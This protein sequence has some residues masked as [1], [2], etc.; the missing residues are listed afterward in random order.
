MQALGEQAVLEEFPEATIVRQARM[1]GHEDW[2]FRQMGF[3]AKF[4]PGSFMPLID[5]GNAKMRPVFVIRRL[6]QVGDVSAALSTMISSGKSCGKLAE[7]Y[8]PREY[9]Y[10]SLVDLFQDVT[11][12]Q[13]RT[14]YAPKM[15]AK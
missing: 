12:R 9:Y 8:G 10:K 4:L 3:F 1:F 14:I 15:I 6:I 13:K 7:L 5:G 11:M 2:F